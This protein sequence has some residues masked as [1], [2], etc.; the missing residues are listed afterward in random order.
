L[1]YFFGPTRQ[2]LPT[3]ADVENLHAADAVLIQ[4]FGDLGIIE[5]RW[6]LITTTRPFERAEWPVPLFARIDLLDPTIGY[7]A[8]YSQ[9][10]GEYVGTSVRDAR[11]LVGMWWDALSMAGAVETILTQLLEQGQ[12]KL[13][14][15]RDEDVAWGDETG[16]PQTHPGQTAMNDQPEM[17]TAIIDTLSRYGSDLNKPHRLDFY[18]YFAAKRAAVAVAQT[19]EAQGFATKVRREADEENWLCLATRAMLPD[20]PT[21]DRLGRWLD[22]L[23]A[24]HGGEFD[25]WESDVI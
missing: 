12:A 13:I 2:H 24:Q 16:L 4:R 11:S 1:G 23:A 5:G 17:G 18:L 22:E 9:E 14:R 7:V 19:L 20:E 3:A 21:L 6:P 25:G 15:I 10:S 8:E